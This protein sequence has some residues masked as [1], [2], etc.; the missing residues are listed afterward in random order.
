[1]N[2]QQRYE[3][4][5]LPF[6]RS[7]LAPKLPP[8]VLDFHTHVWRRNQSRDHPLKTAH[9]SAEASAGKPG[10]GYVATVL[11][12]DADDLLRNARRMFPIGLTARC[13]SANRPQ[14]STWTPRTP[15]PPRQGA[16]TVSTRCGSRAAT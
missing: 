13:V 11:E 16:R 7:V 1:M 14:P 2:E 3:T 9:S 10:G 4:I 8:E 12:Y 15:M 6:Y 5:D